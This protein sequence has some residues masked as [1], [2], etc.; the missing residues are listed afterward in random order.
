MA[1]HD[2]AQEKRQEEH[3]SASASATVGMA[4]AHTQAKASSVNDSTKRQCQLLHIMFPV[5]QVCE[6]IQHLSQLLGTCMQERVK[7]CKRM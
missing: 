5:N 3:S 1:R 2:A 6:N 4:W 7:I